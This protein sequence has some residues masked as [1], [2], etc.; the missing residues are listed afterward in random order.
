MAALRAEMQLLPAASARAGQLRDQMRYLVNQARD[1]RAEIDSLRS[2][3]PNLRQ[4]EQAHQDALQQVRNLE[5]QMLAPGISRARQAAI[6]NSQDMRNGRAAVAQTQ[7]QLRAAYN[8]IDRL[9]PAMYRDA[10]IRFRSTYT[11]GPYPAGRFGR[12]GELWS[13]SAAYRSGQVRAERIFRQAARK[14]GLDLKSLVDEIVY[15]PG[16]SSPFF[17]VRNGRVIVGLND[18]AVFGRDPSLKLIKALH[19]I[20]HAQVHRMGGDAVV[21]SQY[22]SPLRRGY[23]EE[24]F[25]ESQARQALR[26]VLSLRALRNSIEYENYFRRKLNLPEIP[27]P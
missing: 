26:D 4:L 10:A 9:A 21:F 23:A 8:E 15:V 6:R 1:L 25:V 2:L 5:N 17:A 3:C 18:L 7:R 19:E 14:A 11:G 27:L 22:S 20:Y 24:I 16:A 13:S 12:G